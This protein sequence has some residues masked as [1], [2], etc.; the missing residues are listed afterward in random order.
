MF[1]DIT[2]AIE[3]QIYLQ[4]LIVTPTVGHL[5]MVLYD[6]ELEIGDAFYI[7][8]IS[9]SQLCDLLKSRVECP[10]FLGKMENAQVAIPQ[11]SSGMFYY[12]YHY[13]FIK[14]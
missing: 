5:C 14:I 3:A 11:N 1:I 2:W 8:K 6:V 9:Q 7:F 4:A 10:D 13:Y 12:C